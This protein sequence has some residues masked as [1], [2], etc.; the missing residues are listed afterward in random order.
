VP[1]PGILDGLPVYAW[2]MKENEGFT[3]GKVL[4]TIHHHYVQL[5]KAVMSIVDLCFCPGPHLG[6]LTVKHVLPQTADDCGILRLILQA[7]QFMLYTE[8]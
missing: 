3:V 8:Y 7:P 4:T 6:F 1:I 5:A 2:K